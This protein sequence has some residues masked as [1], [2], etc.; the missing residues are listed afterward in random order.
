MT[1]CDRKIDTL[2]QRI[3]TRRH[4]FE[5][6]GEFTALQ[7]DLAALSERHRIITRRLDDGASADEQQAVAR[8]HD[9][10]YQAVTNLERKLDQNE[11][12]EPPPGRKVGAR[13]GLV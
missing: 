8:E 10:I 11:M 3:E 5:E 6:H 13:S 4:N 9:L 12:Q 7:D 1:P 2:A